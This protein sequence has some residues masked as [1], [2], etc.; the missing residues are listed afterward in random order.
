MAENTPL[1]RFVCVPDA[2]CNASAVTDQKAT[3]EAR[4]N[5]IEM[6]EFGTSSKEVDVKVCAN[7]GPPAIVPKEKLE[8][9]TIPEPSYTTL[10]PLFFMV[11]LPLST[12][13][14]LLSSFTI[15]DPAEF[16]R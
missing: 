10:P 15:S 7:P 3:G 6:E 13:M 14:P 1:S 4:F 11:K 9:P 5:I 12:A 16:L 8:V 2:S